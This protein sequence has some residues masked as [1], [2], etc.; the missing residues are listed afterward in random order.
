MS[1]EKGQEKVNELVSV[2]VAAK[3]LGVTEKSVWRYM[4]KGLLTR[5]KEGSRTFIP[6]SDVRLLK[7]D[8]KSTRLNSSHRT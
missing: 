3:A 2:Q 7:A 6:A 1:D 5:V 4:T 8:R